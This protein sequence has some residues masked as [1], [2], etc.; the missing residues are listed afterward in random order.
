MD[1]E[2]VESG[3]VEMG[4]TVGSAGLADRDGQGDSLEDVGSRVGTR[5]TIQ[6]AGTSLRRTRSGKVVLGERE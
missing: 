5:I 1:M 6:G 4:S 3:D 2:G